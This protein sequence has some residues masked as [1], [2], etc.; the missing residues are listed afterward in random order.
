M[1]VGGPRTPILAPPL[2]A[3][4]VSFVSTALEPDAAEKRA[5]GTRWGMGAAFRSIA[6]SG[7]AVAY[8]VC[9]L[10][11]F[12]DGARSTIPTVDPFAIVV[13]DTCS[14]FG[15][16][17]ADYQARALQKHRAWE[18][19]VIARQFW[20]G[21]LIP[22]SFHL[23][24][25]GA[26]NDISPATGAPLVANEALGALEEALGDCMTGA[27]GMIYC[28]QRVFLS[29]FLAVGLYRLPSSSLVRTHMDN[30]V[31]VDA[32]FPG[33]GPNGEAATATQQ[34]MYATAPAKI[35]R[36]DPVIYPTAAD[37]ASNPNAWQAVA[38]DHNDV[39]FRAE[40]LA[41]VAV[42][43]CCLICIKVAVGTAAED[44][45]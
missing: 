26:V 32:G 13:P 21:A 31:A 34:W 1:A 6:C 36:S 5:L 14:T 40:S 3:P 24:A 30:V 7:D 44:V 42:D 43:P 9:D 20:T 29:L 8:D 45:T 18:S 15:F 22:N 41:A 19:Y 4:T 35:Y 11:A 38:R 10:P 39:T 33:S 23:Q 28:S 17:Y 25:G 37:F 12:D 2:L 16:T 27:V